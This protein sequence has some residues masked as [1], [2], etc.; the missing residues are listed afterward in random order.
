MHFR[1]GFRD[2]WSDRAQIANKTQ[3]ANEKW[4]IV[5]VVGVFLYVL[6]VASPTTW[7]YIGFGTKDRPLHWFTDVCVVIALIL[8]VGIY[9]VAPNVCLLGSARIFRRRLSSHC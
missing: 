9:Y 3:I 4:G 1:R 8:S 6:N 7:A 5:R 2:W